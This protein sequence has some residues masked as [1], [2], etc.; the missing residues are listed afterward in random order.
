MLV[1]HK[2][3]NILYRVLYKSLNVITQ[4]ED[5]VYISMNTGVIFNK[6]GELFRKS[7]EYLCNPQETVVPDPDQAELKFDERS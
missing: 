1:R 3:S 4:R 2:K 6:D 7:M 5:T